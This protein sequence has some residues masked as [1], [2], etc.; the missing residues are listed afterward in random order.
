LLPLPSDEYYYYLKGVAN[1]LS[2]AMIAEE[3]RVVMDTAID[4]AFYVFNED[5]T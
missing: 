2:L 5:G 1:I 3:K 4:N